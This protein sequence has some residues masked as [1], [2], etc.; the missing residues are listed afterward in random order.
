MR[1]LWNNDRPLTLTGLAML[2][3]LA[4]TLLGLW[5]DPRTIT[6][7]PAWL[8]PSK[9]A[10]SIAIYCLTLAWAFG[11]L[12]AWPRTRRIVGRTSAAVFFLEFGIIALQA[13]RGTTSHFNTSTVLDAV[14]FAVMGI[15]I[16]VQTMVSIA[17]A[18]ACW[19]ER[20][21]DAALGWALRL[22]MTISIIGASIA[23]LMTTPTAAQLDAARS[24][25]GLPISGAHTVGAVDG[26][27]GIPGTGWSLEH[28]DL[29]VPHFFGL[30]A[31]QALPLVA[32]ALRRRRIAEAVRARLVQ[33]A[34]ASYASLFLLLFWQ[35]LRGESLVRPDPLMLGALAAWAAGTAA[36]AWLSSSG[37]RT[38][39]P[40]AIAV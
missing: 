30:H 32:V 33:V 36:A 31:L 7:A 27:A 9:F 13:W 10:L 11:Y 40:H 34:G 15:G 35:A 14:L 26:G 21:A 4:L 8:K 6:N 16:L 29:R 38:V 17:V 3:L 24:G 19:R 2:G 1:R 12:A 20:F 37:A 22:G 23:G 25:R 28:G 5:L 39:R 18:V